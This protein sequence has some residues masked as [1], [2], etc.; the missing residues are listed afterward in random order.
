MSG[1]ERD[2]SDS[3]SFHSRVVGCTPRPLWDWGFPRKGKFSQ[4]SAGSLCRALEL[5]AGS[6]FCPY[7]CAVCVHPFMWQEKGSSLVPSALPPWGDLGLTASCSPV[8]RGN[9]AQSPAEML[10]L[11]CSKDWA[12]TL[13]L[14]GENSLESTMNVYEWK[15]NGFY[16]ESWSFAAQAVWV[17]KTIPGL[18]P[19]RVKTAWRKRSKWY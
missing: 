5:V 4:N 9:K 7:P 10:R 13:H 17:W 1:E 12:L 16:A 8:T 6:C 15:N 19:Q 14:G 18:G 11:L 2:V 3:V